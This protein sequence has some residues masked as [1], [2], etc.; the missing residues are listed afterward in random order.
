MGS[1][2]PFRIDLFDDEIESLRTFDPESQRTLET[3][4][5]LRLLPAKEFPLDEAALKGFKDRWH[6]AFDVDARACPVYQDVAQ[7][8]APAGIEYYLPLF[9]DALDSLPSYLPEGT[10]VAFLEGT[11]PAAEAFR[12]EV[13]GRFENLRYDSQRPILPPDTLFQSADELFEQ[14]GRFGQLRLS[15][16]AGD[17]FDF[18]VRP[19]P[20][21]SYSEDAQARLDRLKTFLAGED[22]PERILICAESAG[23]RELLRET[24]ARGGLA[25]TAVS[26]LEAFFADGTGLGLTLAPLFHG[27]HLPAQKLAVI[28]EADLLG[29]RVQ[30]SRRRKKGAG[31]A[32][33]LIVRSL[34]ELTPGAPVVHNEHGVGRYLGLESM[35]LDDGAQE[36]LT[37]E[38]AGAASSTCPSPTCTSSPAIAAPMKPMR[39][40]TAWV[41]NN[42][43]R[44]G[45]RPRKRS[46]TSP[47]SFSISTPAGSSGEATLSRPRTQTTSA[48]PVPSPSRRRT[49]RNGPLPPCSRT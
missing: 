34:S 21:L 23:R 28:T 9:F 48:L 43:R 37:L 2:H 7:G 41:R 1:A 13:N 15:A 8:S 49:T 18:A 14:L 25:V 31:D 30:Q 29:E 20:D 47:P 45:A 46:G 35:A 42:G 27:F 33:E 32:P 36:F 4:D 19:L 16:D 24:L 22:A 40:C 5:D 26:D 10:L 38:Y 44:P 11:G 3:L 6:L 17:G 39:P 12:Q